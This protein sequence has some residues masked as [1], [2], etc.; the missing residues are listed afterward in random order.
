MQ[1][2]KAMQNTAYTE[3]RD[4]LHATTPQTGEIIDYSCRHPARKDHT[5]HSRS[6]GSNDFGEFTSPRSPR[7]SANTWGQGKGVPDVVK[8]LSD[9]SVEKQKRMEKRKLEQDQVEL[10]EVKTKPDISPYN[11]KSLERVPLHMRDYNGYADK[12]AE[13]QKRSLLVKEL[14]NKDECTFAP[15]INKKKSE[16]IRAKTPI[17]LIEW[18]KE[19]DNMLAMMRMEKV[20]INGS[21]C[22]FKPS[23]NEKSKRLMES[24]NYNSGN[25]IPLRKSKKQYIND[26]V[27]K[28]QEDLFKPKINVSSKRITK[29]GYD[30]PA[31]IEVR[32]L[33]RKPVQNHPKSATFSRNPSKD[34]SPIRYE[35]QGNPLQLTADEIIER[36]RKE[37][38]PKKREK[39]VPF[40]RH[41]SRSVIRK[42][43]I[44]K[45]KEKNLTMTPK[46]L[47]TGR[48]TSKDE[49]KDI[50]KAAND[51]L[52][53]QRKDH[54]MSKSPRK[55]KHQSPGE[56]LNAHSVTADL[57]HTNSCYRLEREPV[58]NQNFNSEFWY[59]QVKDRN[60]DAFKKKVEDL[61]YR[62]SL[63]KKNPNTSARKSRPSEK[64]LKHC[65]TAHK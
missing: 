24:K 52:E 17:E 6:K 11:Y 1:S 4:S 55:R 29:A 46:K 7:R 54:Q 12:R 45:S 21:E 15:N 30:K 16:Q 57:A 9:M 50:M 35:K 2:N 63:H 41:T 65:S 8:R 34:S 43:L 18:K 36:Y 28:E 38:K 33:K 48:S 26:F 61:I 22:T 13:D 25:G 27:K 59:E 49:V 40:I 62:D 32:Q 60:Q 47:G 31:E 44:D 56:D 39:K 14:K 51:K 64:P 23:I 58:F 5:N 53:S 42:S 20:D 19:K 37:A 10:N 3:V